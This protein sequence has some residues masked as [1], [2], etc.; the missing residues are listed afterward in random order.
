[1]SA[2]QYA[3]RGVQ[4]WR[5]GGVQSP[6]E[7]VTAPAVTC[8]CFE[9]LSEWHFG[10]IASSHATMAQAISLAKELSDM[11][12]L[13]LAL[14]FAGVLAHFEGDPDE[15][16]RLGS[17]VIE[18]STRHSFAHW[19]AGGKIL[20]GWARCAL[21]LTAEGIAWI[22]S[23]IMDWRATGSIL[24]MPFHLTLKAKAFY[25]ANHTTK[26]LEA[27]GEAEALIARS[28]ECWWCAELHRLRGVFLTTTGADETQIGVSFRA[29]I[30][31]AR[32]QKSISLEKRA[33]STYAEYRKQRAT[34][35]GVQEWGTGK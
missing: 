14:W 18:L 35:S 21:G 3:M 5:S 17:D 20:S 1:M 10:E 15:V 11:H 27:I 2:R 29:A 28:E 7:E 30:R 12:A 8:L 25:L 33:E 32:K 22:E 26:A 4:I 16:K 24:I 13:A 31:I 6:V 9:A 23:G 34:S 19:L